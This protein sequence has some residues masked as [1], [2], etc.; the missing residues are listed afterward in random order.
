MEEFGKVPKLVILDGTEIIYS[1]DF[2]VYKAE[3]ELDFANSFLRFRSFNINGL[4]RPLLLAV[5][6]QANGESD[7]YQAHIIAKKCG[8]KITLLDPGPIILAGR[9]GIF[10]RTYQ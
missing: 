10:I 8:G 9:D 4:P 7:S 5:A 6:Y 1:L 3:N 2:D